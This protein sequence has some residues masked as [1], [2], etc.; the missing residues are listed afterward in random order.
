VGSVCM[1]ISSNSIQNRWQTT[2]HVE[3]L[4]WGQQRDRSRAQASWVHHTHA[5]DLGRVLSASVG[6][7][8]VAEARRGRE[9][10]V[11]GSGVGES[12]SRSVR[13]CECKPSHAPHPPVN[14]TPK[15]DPG[16]FV[17]TLG[18]TWSYCAALTSTRVVVPTTR[19]QPGAH[20]SS[21]GNSQT[22]DDAQHNPPIR[23]AGA[24]VGGHLGLSHG[25]Q[26][27]PLEDQPSF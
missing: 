18:H 8:T 9:A 2:K 7:F 4:A 6:I 10:S 21:V 5:T 20:C 26:A 1:C 25:K 16:Y 15:W 23:H 12:H 19:G 17:A 24:D 27:Q 14:W 13:N 3:H 11:G 22:A